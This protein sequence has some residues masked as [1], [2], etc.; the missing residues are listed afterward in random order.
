VVIATHHDS[1][2]SLAIVAAQAGKHLL[3]E[4]P[5]GLDVPAC[6][7]VEHAV[8]AAGVQL[9]MGFQARCAPLAQRARDWVPAP[10][11]VSGS[12]IAGRWADDLWAQLPDTGGGNVLS[13][14]VH[15]FDLL[16]WA[17]GAPPQVIFA[18][19]GTITHDPATTDVVDSVLCTIRFANGA[20]DAHHWRLRPSP[21]T[22]LGFY[23]L[24]DAR[25]RSA[26]PP[27]LLRGSQ[28]LALPSHPVM[29]FGPP[30]EPPEEIGVTDRAGR[31][32][33]SIWLAPRS[34]VRNVH[35][36]RP[37]VSLRRRRARRCARPRRARGLREHSR[38]TPVTLDD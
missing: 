4:K 31:T 6:R 22:L 19:G 27:S 21:W 3:V 37:S 17:A 18:E 12:L 23:Q 24:F 10:R 1:H 28:P 11:I 15:A 25:S 16:S 30:R 5:L 38:R 35:P 29:P 9:L 32:R 33:R 14:G 7:A 2:P 34:Q 20:G 26:T 13:Q 36:N 8:H